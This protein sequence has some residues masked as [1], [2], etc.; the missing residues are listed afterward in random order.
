MNPKTPQHL[1]NEI[2]SIPAGERAGALFSQA[3]QLFHSGDLITASGIYLLG[4]EYAREDGYALAASLMQAC[5]VRC[6]FALGAEA[7][8]NDLSDEVLESLN[9]HE[10]EYQELLLN[11]MAKPVPESIDVSRI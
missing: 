7:T 8:A 5:R 6:L 11:V 10:D 3:N 4:E 1:M 2:V 9:N